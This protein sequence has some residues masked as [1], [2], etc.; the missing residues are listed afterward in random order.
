MREEIELST[1]KM[2]ALHRLFPEELGIDRGLHDKIAQLG[3]KYNLD[4]SFASKLRLKS[5]VISEEEEFTYSEQAVFQGEK[6]AFDAI[7]FGDSTIYYCISPQIVDEITKKNIAFFAFPGAYPS[8]NYIKAAEDISK[9]YL[10]KEGRVF[11]MFADHHWALDPDGMQHRESMR[12]F[13]R[14]NVSKD[15]SSA[16]GSNKFPTVLN[17]LLRRPQVNLYHN[18]LYPV[19]TSLKHK[20]WLSE[21]R[22]DNAACALYSWP[23][24]GK[25]PPHLLTHCTKAEK[26]NLKADL[27]NKYKTRAI[28]ESHNMEANIKIFVMSKLPNKVLLLPW[29]FSAHFYSQAQKWLEQYEI[30]NL[31]EIISS[32]YDCPNLEFDG[33]HIVNESSIEGSIIF[34]EI[35]KQYL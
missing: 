23:Q 11:F 2:A 20:T 27:Y 35:I 32:Q 31:P 14:D 12:I 26:I 7:I 9:V 25:R 10:K 5:P 33:T 17:N 19:I 28:E 1:S 18:V 3:K 29:R 21:V 15:N 34:A 8:K 4:L 24:K 22:A 6:Q 13:A 30:I 16:N